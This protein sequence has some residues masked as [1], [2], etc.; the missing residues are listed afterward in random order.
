MRNKQVYLV[1]HKSKSD[2]KMHRN[3]FRGRECSFRY[4]CHILEKYLSLILRINY[5]KMKKL[6]FVAHLKIK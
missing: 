3:V 5:F 2:I 6:S 1:L 4:L